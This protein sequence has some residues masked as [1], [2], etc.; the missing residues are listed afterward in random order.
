M[1]DPALLSIEGLSVGYGDA[2]AVRDVSLRLDAGRA[3]GIVGESGSGKSSIAGAVLGLLDAQAKISG[4]IVFEGRDLAPLP[5]RERRA[6]LGRRIGTVFQDPFTTLNPSLRVGWQIAEPMMRHLRLDRGAALDRATA[7]LADMGVRRAADVARAFPHQLS[8]GMKQRALIAAAL[9]C[10][11]P[12]LILDEPTTALDVTVEA[13]ILD[14]LADLRLR[15]RIGVLFITHNLKVARRI[16]DDVAVM[17]AGQI[18]ERGAAD[19]VL[20]APA[21]PYAKG[22]LAS[23]PL[24]QAAARECRL[25]SIP[26]QMSDAARRSHGC[27][28]S[29]RCLFAEPRCGEPQCLEQASRGHDVRCW[30]SAGVGSWPTPAATVARRAEFARGDALVNL[31]GLRK[32]YAARPNL[33]RRALGVRPSAAAVDDVSLSVSPGE[34]LGLVGESGCGKSTLGRLALRLLE[35]D[36]G[37]VEFDG[38]NLA[39]LRPSEL[40]SFRSR[41]QLVFQNV[42][43][44]LNPRLTVDETLRRPLD[45]F[46]IGAKADRTARV[47][48]LL[49]MVRL[50]A[51]CRGRL[52]RG[53]SGGERQ[54]V[55]I[56]RALATNPRFVVC[57]EPVSALDVSVQAAI[58]NLLADLRDSLGLAYLFIS[59]D[60]AA[61]GQIADRIAVMH[62]GRICET[63]SADDVLSRPQ[64]PYTQALLESARRV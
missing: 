14:L 39:S 36:A 64:H 54:R 38:A 10:E 37:S 13:Q 42:G 25:P 23:A 28:F 30:K 15:K 56:A 20:G 16:C 24:L 48:Q 21:H 34:V 61:V 35:A 4:R 9:A 58:L 6:I 62:Q 63:G 49:D 18:V 12:L 7:L 43:S 5:P 50:P 60:L 22:L 51:S 40:R 59:H 53:L 19:A 17:Y 52:P 44:A 32:S 26:G 3:L 8:G 2:L 33:L 27:S 57:D 11:P 55:A 1:S 45:L 47:E 41:A 31:A 29:A 46:G